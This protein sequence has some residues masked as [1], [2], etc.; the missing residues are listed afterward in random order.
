[1]NH[2]KSL[3]LGIILLF[4]PFLESNEFNQK[5]WIEWDSSEGM[6]RL[7]SS[8]AKENFWKLTR[9]Y[10]SQIRTTYCG[11]ASSVVLLNAL[12]IKAPPSKIFEKYNFFNQEEFLS[13]FSKFIDQ[14]EVEKRGLS[15]EELHSLLESLPLKIA[16]YKAQDLTIEEMR[17]LLISSLK[18]PNHG[19][20]ALYQRKELMQIG[21]GHWS[22]IAAYDA[23]SDS[24]LLMD[25]ARFK[26]P[27]VWIN[28]DA[29]LK[30]MQTSSTYGE[31]RGFLIIDNKNE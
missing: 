26:Y 7:Q 27:P 28:A 16:K 13:N 10:E 19:I 6:A 18:N 30:S 20:L 12:S 1:M 22:P 4:L 9:F 23:A 3:F 29:F 14:Q 25:V 21:G 24:F 11:V 15:L 2:F 17:T 5:V 31:S 8:D